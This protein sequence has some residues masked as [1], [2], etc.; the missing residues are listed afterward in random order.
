MDDSV[1]ARILLSSLVR[2]CLGITVEDGP[3]PL[4]PKLK[5]KKVEA[6]GS[7]SDEEELETCGGFLCPGDMCRRELDIQPTSALYALMCIVV[8]TNCEPNNA[9][10]PAIKEDPSWS[11]YLD[12]HQVLLPLNRIKMFEIFWR[13]S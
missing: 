12:R 13:F 9:A 2:Q 10:I 8:T 5:D 3:E 4:K 11:S 7:D 1:I 6:Q